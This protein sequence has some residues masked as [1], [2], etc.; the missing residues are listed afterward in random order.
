MVQTTL[1]PSGIL[2]I[3][4][5]PGCTSHDVLVQLKRKLKLKRIGHTGT[6]DPMATGLL[7]CVVGVAT[8]LA[9][10]LDGEKKT[11]SGKIKLG[12]QTDTDDVTGKEIAT[13]NS[14]PEFSTIVQAVSNFIGKLNQI[15]PAVSA[16]KV[17]G[18]RSYDLARRGEAK[19]LSPRPVTI[20]EFMIDQVTPDV[21]SFKV[22]CSRG[23]YIRALARDLGT[24]LGCGG[25]LKT[26]RRDDVGGYST[27]QSVTLDKVTLN[28]IIPLS[29]VF[30]S[31]P[32][33]ILPVKEAT[34]LKG[35][36]QRVISANIDAINKIAGDR[37][38]ILY[39]AEGLEDVALGVLELAE[40]GW[41]I[42][43]NFG[44]EA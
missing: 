4:K 27:E 5:P 11:Y 19:E 13:S 1:N 14:I 20:Y 39:F 8:R 2:L 10:F 22:V 38:A 36:E 7:V 28:D 32:R 30:E 40:S 25:C 24:L 23:T 6:L 12:L 34:A 35:G 9:R 21:V 31:W 15:P 17:A 43:F 16:V 26:L 44:E 18:E 37:K 29:Q 33:L 3:D 41:K 42:A